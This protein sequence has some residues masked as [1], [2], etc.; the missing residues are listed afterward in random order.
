MNVNSISKDYTGNITRAEFCVLA[1]NLYKKLTGDTINKNPKTDFTD[2]TNCSDAKIR[3]IC[4]LNGLGVINGYG[5]GRFGPSDTLTREQAAVILT[6]LAEAVGKP[7]TS[8]A[9]PFTDT[10]TAWSADGIAKCY[11]SVIMT[12]LSE[13][14]FGPQNTYTEQQAIVT[15]VK[16][17]EYASK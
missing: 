16:L 4:N 17:Y 6:K 1:D 13:T 7:L 3:A 9:T 10:H 12:G 2:I 11:G 8:A 15:M 14:T 5:D